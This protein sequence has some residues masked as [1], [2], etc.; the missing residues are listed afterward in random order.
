[1]LYVPSQIIVILAFVLGGAAFG[2]AM[3]R[4][5]LREQHTS[6]YSRFAAVV[7]FFAAVVF[8]A[9]SLW[10][11][12][13]VGRRFMAQIYTNQG[14]I[15]LNQGDNDGA[16]ARVRSAQKIE[17]TYDA[18]RLSV[19]V[20]NAVL[21]KI[22]TTDSPTPSPELQAQFKAE[23][24]AIITDGQR[25]IAHM[26]QDYRGYMG[27]AKAYDLFA[28]LK[29]SGAYESAKKSYEDAAIY[30]P[31]NPEIALSLAR[32]D[33]V[34]GSSVSVIEKNLAKALTLK[35]DYTDAILFLVQLN[36]ANKDIPNAIK[37]AQAA[38]RSA[39]GVP[40]IWFQLGLLYYTAGDMDNASTVLGQAV[41][42]QPDYANAK[43]FL[44]LAYAA[45]GKTPE[46]VQQFVD[47]EKTNPDNQEVKLILGN[48]R[49]GKPPFE[50]AQPPVTDTPEERTTAPI[51]Q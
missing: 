43:Y 45:S 42:L 33:A 24:E 50:N 44:G 3:H 31:K 14:F 51:A 13:S 41:V 21:E 26:P 39:P 11:A 10:C 22:V 38:V 29:I 34:Q 23:V 20:H 35:S 7:F 6:D 37:A 30:N 4:L 49:A 19:A 18:L 36:V 17:P 8:V 15:L 9:V 46:A 27:L 47:L 25:A 12:F 5:S 2:F 1:V 28:S 40:V 16:L 48:L 32:L